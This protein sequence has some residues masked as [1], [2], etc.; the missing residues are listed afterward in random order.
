M[1]LIYYIRLGQFKNMENLYNRLF[2]YK[3]NENISPS[4]N[5]ITE[6]FVYLLEFSLENNTTFLQW[7]FENIGVQVE[8][9]NCQNL[10]I[11]TQRQFETAYSLN[12]IPDL[13]I[14]IDSDLY[15]FEVKYDSDF[16]NYQ[17]PIDSNRIINQIEKY[18]AIITFPKLNL[19]I[20][21]IVLHSSTID[22]KKNNP[23]FKQEILWHDIYNLIK[24]Y[25]SNNSV[26]QYLHKE[27]IK[28][29]E[30][31]RMAVPKV[32]YELVNGMQS[33]LNLYEQ[34]EIVLEK[35]KIP[36]NVSF[37]Y[38]WTGYYLFKD[39]SKSD[40]DYAWIGTYWE[41]DKLTFIFSNSYAQENIITKGIENEFD[42][43]KDNKVFCKYFVFE[44]EHFFCLT[45]QEQ[46]DKL[47]N[48]I[49]DN[50]LLLSD[51]CK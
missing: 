48:W 51:L 14:Q 38:N 30:E 25:I 7:F 11:N 18:Q 19:N 40:K 9:Q 1:A 41:I 31:N 3:P 50:Y 5:F 13:C 6:S 35:L 37:G 16:N 10:F 20:Y 8:I 34:I 24:N 12:A 42:R 47:Q 45:E 33:L 28:F 15:V 36:Y 4:E 46:I 27:L 32:S 29:L 17:L 22:F 43:Q 39:E 26:E 21:T 2:K 23:D 49:N 44:K